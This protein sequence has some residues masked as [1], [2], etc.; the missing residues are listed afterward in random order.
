VSTVADIEKALRALSV[1]DARAVADWLQEY[2]ED[3]WD[4][5]I[6]LDA[7]S[8]KLDK[9][10]AQALAHYRSGRVKPVDELID[11]S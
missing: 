11:N 4:H 3:Q 8:G 7:E 10:G 1:Q 5:Q 9:L 6:A 2:L